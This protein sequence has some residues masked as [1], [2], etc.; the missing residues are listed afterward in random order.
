MDPNKLSTLEKAFMLNN[1]VSTGFNIAGAIDERN[2]FRR[3][4]AG[5][6]PFDLAMAGAFRNDNDRESGVSSYQDYIKRIG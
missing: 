3:Q 4:R 6:N 5:G 2:Q 1:I